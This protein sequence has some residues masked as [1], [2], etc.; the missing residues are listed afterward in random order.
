LDFDL[1]AAAAKYI[2]F[3]IYESANNAFL[4]HSSA[5]VLSNFPAVIQTKESS[6]NDEQQQNLA[7]SVVELRK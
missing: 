4:H 7:A 2:V 3:I 6:A 1:F 5:S